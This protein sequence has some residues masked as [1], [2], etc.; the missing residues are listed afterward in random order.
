MSDVLIVAESESVREG[1]RSLLVREG[2]GARVARNGSE[3]MRKLAVRRPDL[4][5]LEPKMSRMSG[6]RICELI[7]R[8]DRLMPVIFLSAHASTDEQLRALAIG[9]D[10]YVSQ[11]A[12]GNVL[13]AR[14][15]RAIARLDDLDEPEEVLSIG[16]VTVGLESLTVRGGRTPMRLTRTERDILLI[17][18]QREGAYIS[19]E[20]LVVALRGRGYACVRGLVYTH[21][22]NLRRK[23]GPS[24]D[25]LVCDRRV[26]YCLNRQ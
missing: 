22:Y 9:G 16:R 5:L 17:L 24:G 7:R 1:A 13:L 6:F 15:R 19:R 4:V 25:A 18:A 2:F 26:G 3:G 14:I 8:A 21:M 11:L 10:D 12:G 23:L 20:Q